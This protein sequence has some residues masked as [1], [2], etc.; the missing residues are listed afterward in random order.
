M[1]SPWLIVIVAVA[2]RLLLLPDS[3]FEVDSVLLTRAVE[4]FD[5]THMRPHPPGYA[6]VVLLGKLLFFLAPGAALRVTSAL[7]VGPLVWGTWKVTEELDGNPL[8]AA[9]LVACNPVAWFYGL[10]ENAYAP[11]AAATVCTVWA[12]L[13]A[14]REEGPLWPILAGLLFGLTGAMR[15]SLLVFLAPAVLVACGRRSHWVLLGAVAPTLLWLTGS[16]WAS[17]GL[18]DYLYSVGNQF[19]WIREGHPDHWRWHQV[20]HLAVYTL[21]AI[22][23]GLLLLP[24]IRRADRVL[25]AW[26]LVPFAFHLVVYVAKAGYLL[27]YLPALCVLLACTQAPRPLRVAAPVISALLFL[28]LRPMDVERD[29]T[30]KRPFAEK[31]WSERVASE[32]SFLATASLGRV[33]VQQSANEGYRSLLQPMV[34]PGRTTVVWVDRWDAAIAGHMLTGVDVVDPRGDRLQVPVEGTRVLYLGWEGP[35]DFE[36]IERDGYGAWMRDLAIDE[37]PLSIGRLEAVPVY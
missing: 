31:S 13:R 24:W 15:P 8:L 22:G 14:R 32:L 2:S 29:R 28:L 1:K 9:A 7:C 25:L 33:R 34:K 36:S 16:A 23:G 20:H 30:P 11:G 4:D 10:T 18:G 12:L 37:L 19:S 26:M 3:P 6:G 27:S 21:Q 5:P 35:E 17:G